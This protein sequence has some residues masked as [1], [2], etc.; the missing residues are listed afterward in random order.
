MGR[1]DF[2][3]QRARDRGELFRPPRSD[4]APAPTPISPA[5]AIAIVALVPPLRTPTPPGVTARTSSPARSMAPPSDRSITG[6]DVK[7][8]LTAGDFGPPDPLSTSRRDCRPARGPPGPLPD[9]E[10]A[11]SA[12]PA[13]SATAA[14]TP[15]RPPP[16]RPSAAYRAADLDVL[17]PRPIAAVALPAS[18]RPIKASADSDRSACHVL[19]V[20]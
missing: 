5:T 20:A 18:H 3:Q 12:S 17:P 8:S 10:A 6:A 15:R 7:L 19:S 14:A 2:L 4:S 13:R 9:G 16:P 1:T 11:R